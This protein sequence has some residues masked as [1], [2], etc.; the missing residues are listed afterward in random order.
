MY[1]IETEGFLLIIFSY[2]YIYIWKLYWKKKMNNSWVI[3]SIEINNLYTY[4]Y[5]YFIF[6]LYYIYIDY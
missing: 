4:I 3:T 6:F 1:K 2:I 5:I